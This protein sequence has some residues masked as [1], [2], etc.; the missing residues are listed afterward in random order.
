MVLWVIMESLTHIYVRV[1]WLK[2]Y[3]QV[4]GF[5]GLDWPVGEVPAED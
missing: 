2:L 5:S 4:S 1:S 3:L